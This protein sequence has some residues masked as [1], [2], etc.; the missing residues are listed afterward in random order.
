MLFRAPDMAS[1]TMCQTSHT[2][3]SSEFE[4]EPGKQ[5]Q[6]I[7]KIPVLEILSILLFHSLT[8]KSIIFRFC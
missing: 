7:C 5:A 1:R 3:H 6:F 4:Q 8:L 2:A